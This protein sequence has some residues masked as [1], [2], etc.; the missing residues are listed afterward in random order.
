M[1]R[2]SR[3]S[4]SAMRSLSFPVPGVGRA[5]R[6]G[7]GGRRSGGAP[8]SP[9]AF[10]PFIRGISPGVYPPEALDALP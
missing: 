3:L 4:R 2:P 5:D 10:V 6:E 7:A 9:S 8:T 1:G